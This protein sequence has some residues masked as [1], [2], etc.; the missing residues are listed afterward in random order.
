MDFEKIGNYIDSLGKYG[1][2]GC[3]IMITKDH[4]V[5]YRHMMGYSDSEQ[6]K[7]L[8]GDELYL[9]FSMTKVITMVAFMQLYEKGL[10]DFEDN[11][12]EYLPSFKNIRV[13]KDGIE[14]N[15][16]NPIKMKHLVSMQSGLDYDLERP[17]IMR[18]LKEKG[19]NAT[20]MDIVTA[21][22]ESP[23]I[24]EPG[25]HFQYSLSH[26]VVAAVIEKIS[27]MTFGEYLKK[28]IFEP[29]GMKNTR[30]ARPLNDDVPNLM[31]QYIADE[32]GKTAPME[33]TC[34]YQL[35]D[36]YESGGAGLL[37]CIE[38]Y[39]V[40]GDT[41]SCG[42]ISKTGVRILKPETI[43]I[44]KKDLLTPQGHEDINQNM[45]R[46]GYGY[47]CGMQ[48]LMEPDLIDSK[49]PAGLFGWDGAAGS[50]IIMD[51]N[52]H[53]SMVYTQH[54]RNCGNAYGI[55]HPTLRDLVFGNVTIHG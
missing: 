36:N 11:L 6:K 10:V 37:S 43:E 50:I 41:I 34:N 52:T 53:T 49:A 25:T 39:S 17:G 35:S 27:G 7:K 33:Q 23:L 9:M 18:V 22:P 44:M 54:V 2:P 42:G 38:D 8:N 46:T 5:L 47:G 55:I 12:Y 19:M 51:T 26:D 30:F 4:E 29:L 48:V 32:N 16:E 15:A 20:T 40:F 14:V 45:G 24:F 1:I 13:M 31:Q 21:F 28:N 3:D